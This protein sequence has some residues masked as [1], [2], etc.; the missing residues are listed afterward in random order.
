MI[1]SIKL[2]KEIYDTINQFVIHVI[3][4]SNPAKVPMI[5]ERYKTLIKKIEE[6]F[7]EYKK[8]CNESPEE[9]WLANYLDE[10]CFFDYGTYTNPNDLLNDMENYFETH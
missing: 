5:K 8:A 9:S 3:S 7:V 6:Y 10:D 2:S 1:D 4:A